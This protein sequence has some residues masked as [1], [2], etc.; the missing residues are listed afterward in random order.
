MTQR[1]LPDRLM[2]LALS[3]GLAPFYGDIHNHCNISYGHG[4]LASAL[5]RARLQL[6]FVSITGHADWPD[7]PTDIPSIAH[8]VDFHEKGFA[9]LR[10]GWMDHFATLQSFDKP[11][12]FLVFPG[13]EIHSCRDGDYTIVY[14]DLTPAP[15]I[16]AARPSQL[17]SALRQEFGSRAFAF[18]HHIGYRIGARG[19]DWSAFHPE[20][21]PFVEVFSMH[22]G[23]ENS[24]T[25][26]TYL[27]SMG[28]VDGAS[29]MEAGLSQKHRFGIVANTDHHSGFPG[30]YG[31]GRMC[32]YALSQQRDDLWQAMRDRRTNALTGDN[33]H[34]LTAIG[35]AVQGGIVAPSDNATLEIEAVGCGF[36]NTIDVVRNGALFSRISPEL[37]PSA[38][39]PGGADGHIET[40]LTLEMGWGA[41]GSSHLWEGTVALEGGEFLGA[42]P[43]FRGVEVV[44]PLEGRDDVGTLPSI[45]WAK[46]GIS[47]RVSAQANTNNVTSAMQGLMARISAG[48]DAIVHLRVGKL[49]VSVPVSR[50]LQGAYS[51]NLGPID[52][53]AFT[54]HQL[55]LPHRWQWAGSIAL[56][57]LQA[58]ENVYVR[59]RQARGDQM[60]WTSPIWATLHS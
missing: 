36:I 50:L 45:S 28:P 43:R 37:T 23:S 8:I 54:L 55:P 25:E 12:A 11:G 29:T 59:L 33:I 4:S 1:R 52:S 21:S 40:L 17:G 15:M 41:R 44:S 13:Y 51:G 56:G 60:A 30:S 39:T 49:E 5:E 47:F 16:L 26:R 31:H 19:I 2:P 24:L 35:D 20:L 34:L 14:R 46:D 10:A 32:V 22:G 42:E 58:D 53:P 6:D 18:P 27:H 48:S 38:L 3:H 9:K 7:M 57:R